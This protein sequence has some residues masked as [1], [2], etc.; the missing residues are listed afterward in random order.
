MVIAQ[1]ILWLLVLIGIMI[2]A[3]E[4]GHYWT[5][6]FFDVRIDAFSFGFGPRLFGFR[7]GET[8]FR[9]SAILVGGYVKMAGEDPGDESANDPRSFAA[10]PRWQRL[11]I[12]LAGPTMNLF[13]AVALLT[14]LYMVKFHMPPD[15]RAVVGHVF[16]D[17]AA[18][19]AGV[20]EG[21][22]IVAIDGKENPTWEDVTIREVA[23]ASQSL[24]VKL[25]RNGRTLWTQ[26]T[27]A[28]D[29]RTGVG[30]AGWLEQGEVEVTSLAPGMPAQQAGLQ[31]GDLLLSA[32]GHPIRSQFRLQ[33]I[34]RLGQGKPVEIEY[35][36]QGRRFRV[37]VQPTF[38]Y[39]EGT[40]RWMIGVFL[41]PRLVFAKLAFPDAL[42]ASLRHNVRS[43]GLVYEFLQRILQQ[44]MSPKSLEGPIG[45]ARL[46][47]EAAREGPAAFVGLMSMV[48]LQLAIFNLLPIPIL[49]GGRTL[50]LAVEMLMR[51][52]LS[53]K[54]KETVLKL[55]F[56]VLV[57]AVVFVL[58]NDI[59][60]IL[61]AG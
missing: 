61:P 2:L 55:G 30:Y 20:R 47:G 5:A 49:D 18:T 24:Q 56:V 59:A 12:T 53:L 31:K 50:M 54:L 15:V 42:A 52:D 14:G 39:P 43:A 25:E 8:D 41:Y 9:F 40:G 19:K 48:S 4:L 60:K 1:N 17:S 7:R 13:L 36:R 57:A 35:E 26:V 28:L 10:K 44:R 38:A 34:I 3:H 11:I 21:D 51:R 27:P 22:R 23:G 45:I 16:A 58:Y 33:E 37:A 32:N 46:S 6:R 29:P